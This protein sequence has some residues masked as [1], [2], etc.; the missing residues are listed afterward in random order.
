MHL[1]T[2]LVSVPLIAALSA[3][4]QAA[5][6]A[7]A[8]ADDFN[9]DERACHS[10]DSDEVHI[11][12]CLRDKGW[13]L[14]AFAPA[15]DNTP[16]TTTATAPTPLIKSVSNENRATINSERASDDADDAVI[17]NGKTAVTPPR[18]VDPLQK[19]SIQTWWKAGG[20]AADFDADANTCLAQLGS[21]HTPDYAQHLY[22]QAMKSCLRT[23]GW[24]AGYDP[25][26][27]PLR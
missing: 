26:Y 17:K 10:I 1:R 16:P 27:T 19:I 15:D 12:Q 5:W 22:T 24:Y 25:V 9:R 6:K 7:G 21:D 11:K 23:H 18:A 8:S 2:L 4:Q 3:C 20:Q 14:A 13:T